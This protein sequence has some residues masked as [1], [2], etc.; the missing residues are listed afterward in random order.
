MDV[1]SGMRRTS[2]TG[3]KTGIPDLADDRPLRYRVAL[4]DRHASGD[5]VRIAFRH[6]PRVAHQ[7]LRTIAAV[8]TGLACERDRPRRRSDRILTVRI[9]TV[10]REVDRIAVFLNVRRRRV[11]AS[12]D[13]KSFACQIRQLR[14]LRGRCVWRK[15]DDDKYDDR[16]DIFFHFR[17]SK[18]LRTIDNALSQSTLMSASLPLAA[19]AVGAIS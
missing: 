16:N 5:H 2:G 7:N 9:A 8:I 4:V 19:T 17:N 10:L 14:A 6:I 18:F 12:R 1:R 3:D 13:N 15:C 11:I